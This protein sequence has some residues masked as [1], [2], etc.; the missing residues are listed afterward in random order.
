[1]RLTPVPRKLLLALPA[2]LLLLPAAQPAHA[3]DQSAA[4]GNL[5]Q[6]LQQLDQSSKSFHSATADFEW[7]NIQTEPV[8]DTDIMTG[9]VYYQHQG[10]EVRV[11]AHITQRDGRPY[12]AVYTFTHGV[13]QLYDKQ[14]NQVRK[15]QNASNLG[16]Y[17]KLGFGSSGK[18]LQNDFQVSYL[19]QETV[20]GVKTDKLQLIFKDPKLRNTIPKVTVWIDPVRDVSLKQVFDEGEGMSKTVTFSHMEVNRSISSGEFNFKTN[21]Q[22]QFINQ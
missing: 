16:G 3:A 13:F 6:V 14:L 9:K 4:A 1:M 12:G 18:E 22:T 11:A 17:I 5:Q 2:F 7:K 15:L 8:P 20:D 19:G 10:S 21:K